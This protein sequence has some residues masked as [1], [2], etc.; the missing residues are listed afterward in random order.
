MTNFW[1]VL[2][3]VVDGFWGGVYFSGHVNVHIYEQQ[4]SLFPSYIKF[5]NYLLASITPL[6]SG[7]FFCS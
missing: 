2:H 3:M 4:I 7:N 6:K 1:A 5:S